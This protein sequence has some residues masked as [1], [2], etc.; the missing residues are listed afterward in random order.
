MIY[1]VRS[2]F[3]ES[4]LKERVPKEADSKRKINFF[5]PAPVESDMK[6]GVLTL[7]KLATLR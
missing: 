7:E 5:R 1:S 3:V 2:A 6:D 4:G